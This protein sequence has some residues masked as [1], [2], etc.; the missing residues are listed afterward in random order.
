MNQTNVSAVPTY[1]TSTIA[2]RIVIAIPSS[3]RD[4]LPIT[5]AE[6]VPDQD[7]CR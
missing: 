1:N 3:E 5:Y 7:R 4:R 2:C 6:A